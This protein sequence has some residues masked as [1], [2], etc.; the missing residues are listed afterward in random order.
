MESVTKIKDTMITYSPIWVPCVGVCYWVLSNP[1]N[2]TYWK[3]RWIDLQVRTVFNTKCI[4]GF[5]ED[6]A[7]MLWRC[8]NDKPNAI[9]A[10][11]R[12]WDRFDHWDYC[13]RSF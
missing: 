5:Y 7:G 10:T 3:A 8:C 11:K 9:I 6:Y 13:M 4:N 12:L 1:D 2:I